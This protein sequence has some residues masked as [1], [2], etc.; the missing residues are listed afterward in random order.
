LKTALEASQDDTYIDFENTLHS[1]AGSLLQIVTDSG[2]VSTIRLIHDSLRDFLTDPSL[3]ESPFYINELMLQ[4]H[5]AEKCVQYLQK[6]GEG[7]GFVIYSGL[8]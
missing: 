1:Q 4:G 6:P 8:N 2:G 3:C 7:H 5:I